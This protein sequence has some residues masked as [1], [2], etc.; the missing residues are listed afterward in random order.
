[1]V[2][3]EKGIYTEKKLQLCYGMCRKVRDTM[4][5]GGEMGR[6]A[7][8]EDEYIM[9]WNLISGF[10]FIPGMVDRK[11]DGRVFQPEMIS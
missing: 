4:S 2:C 3:A 5:V 6:Q 7:D 10:S 11:S 9:F 1:M 8:R